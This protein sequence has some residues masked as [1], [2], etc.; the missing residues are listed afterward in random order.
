[1]VTFKHDSKKS[2]IER[3]RFVVSP[4]KNLSTENDTVLE[5]VQS[6][7]NVLKNVENVVK[8]VITSTVEYDVE[9]VSEPAS[10]KVSTETYVER[11]FAGGE[12]AAMDTMSVSTVS[13]VSTIDYRSNFVTTADVHRQIDVDELETSDSEEGTTEGYTDLDE[14]QSS[15]HS[16]QS[17]PS[18]LNRF[19]LRIFIT[20]C[21]IKMTE[22]S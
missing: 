14:V 20:K 1:M 16:I 21:K 2:S 22:G 8:N 4:T 18:S 9:S 19:K 12:K 7:E 3:S 13:T 11:C 5:S 15:I 17:I 10:R 6:N